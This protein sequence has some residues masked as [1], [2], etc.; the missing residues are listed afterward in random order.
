MKLNCIIKLNQPKPGLV[1]IGLEEMPPNNHN[2][3]PNQLN[4]CQLI[5]Q[6]FGGRKSTFNKNEVNAPKNSEKRGIANDSS[7]ITIFAS[8]YNLVIFVCVFA[9]NSQF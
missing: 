8:N 4:A 2:D 9:C 5:S 1:A 3:N 6:R 7:L